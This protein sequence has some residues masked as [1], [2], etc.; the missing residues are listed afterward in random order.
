MSLQLYLPINISAVNAIRGFWFTGPLG[1]AQHKDFWDT[2]SKNVHV[3]RNDIK[4]VESHSIRLDDGSEVLADAL[5]CGTGWK[6]YCPYF[7]KEQAHSLGLPHSPE[8]DSP[9]E[10]KLW[11][12][13]LEAADRRVL[14]EFPL[15]N[16]PP[17]HKK[18]E[19]A[20]TTMR[21]Y[22]CMAPLEDASVVFLGYG[23]LSNSFRT[24]E[25]QA[26]WATAFFDG[27]K[28]LPPLHQAQQEVAYMNAFSRRRY[29]SH[30][31]AGDYFFFELVWYTDKLMKEAGLTSHRRGWW[32]DLVDPCLA[33]DYEGM[34]DEYR[35][36]Y[37]PQI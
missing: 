17:P 11:S 34:K 31:A 23:H 6:S 5:L 37:R 7:S 13:L 29:P 36:K 18:A 14:S 22:N 3:Y 19:V 2:L 35:R 21:L 12:S 16:H 8:E 1:L 33:A 10:A 9:E 27:R 32:S 25:G 30:G 24:A 26:I 4:S 28:L 20:K 15:L